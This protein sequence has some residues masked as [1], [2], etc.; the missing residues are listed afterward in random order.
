MFSV[1]QNN[2]VVLEDNVSVT[3]RVKLLIL[4][5]PTEVYNEPNQGVGLKR[6]LWQYNTD[7]Q[8]AIIK[9]RVVEQLR[10][11]EP[12]VLADETQFADG[13]LFTGD[14]GQNSIEQS[15]NTLNMTIAVKSVFGDVLNVELNSINN[16]ASESTT[17]STINSTLAGQV[18]W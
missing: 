4:T 10:I 16:Y 6:H 5:E 7:N 9:D 3:N 13:L 18:S 17:V 12:S 11:H 2:V 14:G 8:K 1:S 15:H